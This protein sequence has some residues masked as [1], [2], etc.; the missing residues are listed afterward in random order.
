MGSN[1]RQLRSEAPVNGGRNY[2]KD[3]CSSENK[4]WLI[5]GKSGVSPGTRR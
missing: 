3:H 4:I 5:A 1:P 2:R